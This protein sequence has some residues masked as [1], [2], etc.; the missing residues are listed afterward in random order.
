MSEEV[1]AA[2][3]GATTLPDEVLVSF[4]D[5]AGELIDF[6]NGSTIPTITINGEGTKG[7]QLLEGDGTIVGGYVTSYIPEPTTTTLSLLALAG[8]AVRRRRK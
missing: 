4:T 3:V 1:W 8:L 6:D 2:I 5:A 7:A